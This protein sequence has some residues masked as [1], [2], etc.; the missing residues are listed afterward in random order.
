MRPHRVDRSIR[1][2]AASLLFSACATPAPPPF[3]A[4]AESAKL[5]QRDAEWADLAMAGK[6]VEKIVSYWTD[7]AVLM[8]PGQPT[9]Q[10][11]QAIRAFVTASVNTPGFKIHWVSEKP[12]FSP[13]GKMAY[14]RGL[15]DL[16]VPGP[17]SGTV[18][19]HL[20]GYTIWRIDADGQWRCVVDIGTEAPA[21]AAPAKT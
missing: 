16:N 7:D 3:D 9:I 2:V 1:L 12:T 8:D 17:K 20:Q 18:T 4:T 6:D 19:V 15:T 5:L 21:P 11:K 13:D 14:M 10:G